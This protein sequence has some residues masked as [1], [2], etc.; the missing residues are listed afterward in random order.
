[1]KS[2]YAAYCL[3]VIIAG[4]ATVPTSTATVSAKEGAA[5]VYGHGG[6]IGGFVKG[7]LPALKRVKDVELT[8]INGEMVVPVEDR[9][10][11]WIKPGKYKLRVSC[12]IRFEISTWRG[13]REIDA[14]LEAGKEYQ[15]GGYVRTIRGAFGSG[16]KICQPTIKEI[17]NA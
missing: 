8:R 17:V 14:T 10:E 16:E 11:Y 2:L 3:V 12:E 7:V 1:M 6:G 15:L 5:V 4:C 13:N 9:R